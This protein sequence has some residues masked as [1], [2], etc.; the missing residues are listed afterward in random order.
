MAVIAR[1]SRVAL[2]LLFGVLFALPASPDQ[3]S[4]IRAV[5]QRVATGLS[6]G[7]P[8][9][10]LNEFDPSLHEYD[11]LRDDFDGLTASYQITN[12]INVVDEQ[13]APDETKAIID[14]T[15]TL[16]NLN[17]PDI[18]ESRSRQI[19]VRFLR[20]KNHWKIVE[21][22]PVDL[23]NPQFRPRSENPPR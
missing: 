12:E 6:E 20:K 13:D 18:H 14:W 4:D 19:H 8:A 15:I 21:F 17:N 1:S 11:T 10:A 2:P 7:N 23:F 3:P 9:D 16:G 22:T 5:L